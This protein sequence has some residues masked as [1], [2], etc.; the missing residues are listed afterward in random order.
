M[1]DSV[2]AVL[3][4]RAS[5]RRN[6][7]LPEAHAGNQISGNVIG[8]VVQDFRIAGDHLAPLL[9]IFTDRLGV[10]FLLSLAIIIARPIESDRNSSSV[11][12]AWP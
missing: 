4:A 11:P 6:A 9:S 12:T 8:A 5:V 1:P 2:K 10:V 7:L 3:I